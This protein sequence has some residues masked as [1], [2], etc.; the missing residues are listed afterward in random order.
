MDRNAGRDR[1]PGKDANV[2]AEDKGREAQDRA[3]PSGKRGGAESP[4]DSMHVDAPKQQDNA[5]GH[6]AP[7]G[8]N[9]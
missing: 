1:N 8:D 7:R 6:R 4:V 5:R 9:S 2:P 3:K